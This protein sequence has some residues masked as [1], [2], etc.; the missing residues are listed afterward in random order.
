MRFPNDFSSRVLTVLLKG[1]DLFRA[2]AALP[3]SMIRY[4]CNTFCNPLI[5]PRR[6]GS[7]PGFGV[8]TPLT[9][10]ICKINCS[11]SFDGKV[12]VVNSQI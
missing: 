4:C 12:D 7:Q 9:S 8:W 11:P 10:Q 3:T 2:S 5:M 1:L 6:E